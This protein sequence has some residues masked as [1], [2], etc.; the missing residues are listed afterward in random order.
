MG[1]PNIGGDI[2]YHND[3]NENCLVTLVTLGIVKEDHIIHSYAPENA[4]G[5]DLVLVGKPTD[6]SGFG[7]ASFASL[8]L[9]EDKKDQNKGAVQEPNAFLERHLLKSSYASVSYT[10]LTLPTICSV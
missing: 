3:Y 8:E 4:N 5:Y 1:V 7:G 2:Y 10:H 6:N 9:E